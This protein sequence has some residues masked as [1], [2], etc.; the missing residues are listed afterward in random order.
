MD[1]TD[2][3]ILRILK[4]N[5]R[6]NLATIADRLNISKATASRRIA[7]LE[8]SGAISSYSLNINYS[9]LGIIK[10]L[11]S[12]QIEGTAIDEVIEPIKSFPEIATISKV[13]GDYSLICE[14]Y[15][16]SVDELYQ[17]VQERVVKLPKIRNVDVSIIIATESSNFDP[18]LDIL[19][20]NAP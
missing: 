18:G 13:F 14:A 10:S 12:I 16:K 8:S 6:E 4:K 19:I 9:D 2:L 15:T 7:K 20:R 17:L 11:I 5:S 3:D 1:K